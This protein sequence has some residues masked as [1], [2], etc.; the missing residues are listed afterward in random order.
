META[1]R[2]KAASIELAVLVVLVAAPPQSFAATCFCRVTANGTEVAKPSKGGFI[3]GVQKEACRSYCRGE[4]DGRSNAD[5]LAWAKLLGQC[6]D[7]AL[8]MEA[9][10]GTANYQE[11]RSTTVNVPCD[12]APSTINPCCPPW[13]RDHLVESLFYQGSGSIAAPYTLK[14]QPAVSLKSQMQSYI[15]YLHSINP[16]M[17]AITMDWRLHDQGTGTAPSTP[18][19]PQVGVTS[20]TTWSS[21]G[22]GTPV[23]SGDPGF[24]SPYPMIVGTWYRVHTGIYLENGQAFFPETCAVNEIWVRVQVLKANREPVLEIWGRDNL[25]RRIPL[26]GIGTK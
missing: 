20:Y 3:Q 21:Q 19:G 12:P 23:I 16:T 4:W 11:V 9:A 6:G 1:M 17:Q 14:F 22:N 10:I 18:L 5:L 26:K 24:F 2:F 13:N 7:I 25:I 8:K 15:D